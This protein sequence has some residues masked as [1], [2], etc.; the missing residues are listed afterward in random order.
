MLRKGTRIGFLSSIGFEIAFLTIAFL[1][2]ESS[3]WEGF[4]YTNYE[5]YNNNLIIFSVVGISMMALSAYIIKMW[6]GK[7]LNAIIVAERL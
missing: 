4:F 5:R 1:G 3:I 6:K 2:I 7:R